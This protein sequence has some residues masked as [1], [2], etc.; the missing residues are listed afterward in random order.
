MI[1]SI[2]GDFAGSC[3]EFSSPKRTDF[4]L[5]PAHAEITDDS[6]LSIATAEVLL[7]NGDYRKLYRQL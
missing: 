4:E 5:F 2:I 6:I 1:G 7:G 3:Y